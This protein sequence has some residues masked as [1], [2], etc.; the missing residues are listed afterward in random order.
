MVVIFE[1]Q[2]FFYVQGIENESFSLYEKTKQIT[3]KICNYLA[4]NENEEIC[5]LNMSDSDFNM[6]LKIIGDAFK[7][8]LEKRKKISFEKTMFFPSFPFKNNIELVLKNSYSERDII[9]FLKKN[10][11]KIESLK[12][13]ADIWNTPIHFNNFE[14][15]KK[16][17]LFGKGCLSFF[18][19]IIAMNAKNIVELEII[20]Y[21]KP[22]LFVFDMRFIKI[23]H[24]PKI[25]K[26][27]LVGIG[28]AK[29]F[30][31]ILKGPS[32][33][34]ESI[35]VKDDCDAGLY[36]KDFRIHNLFLVP[37]IFCIKE[38][39]KIRAKRF[40]CY[41]RMINPPPRKLKKCVL[42]GNGAA[43]FFSF[44]SSECSN[45]EEL[46]IWDPQGFKK[47][48]FKGFFSNLKKCFL[49]GYEADSS[50]FK[51]GLNA[52]C[53]IKTTNEATEESNFIDRS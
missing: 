10:S 16:C 3:E 11:E 15:L 52:E 35:E 27:K 9:M 50:V 44:F 19:H 48:M 38:A 45:L 8:E 46:K 32:N 17:F 49:H 22:A 39:R 51:K 28:I 25:K 14:T 31:K 33:E 47:K 12:I 26:I 7:Y 21:A 5:F 34:I 18:L 40:F 29:L 6:L 23:C 30:T 43:M 4:K 37:C 42:V 53:I 36:F 24:F 2:N 13:E 41:E 1:K 20:D